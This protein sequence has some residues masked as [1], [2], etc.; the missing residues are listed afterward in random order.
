MGIAG[1]VLDIIEIIFFLV[2]IVQADDNTK[3]II[4]K[5]N[6]NIKE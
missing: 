1:I 3:K 2:L 6:E 5:H 4:N